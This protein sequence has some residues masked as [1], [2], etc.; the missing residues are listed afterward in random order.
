MIKIIPDKNMRLTQ[1]DID[2][3]VLIS[4]IDL[5]G[6][7]VHF[8]SPGDDHGAYVVKPENGAA[9]I[10][11]VLLTLAGTVS[12]YV[13]PPDYTVYSVT[14]PVAPREKPD[15]YVYTPSEVLRYETLEKQIGN[16]DDLKTTTKSDLVSAIN[17]AAESGGGGKVDAVT[18]NGVEQPVE[19]KT[20]KIT[21]DKTTVGLG[22]VDNTS[23][24]DKPISTAQATA[25]ADA[26]KAGT[27][28]QAAVAS[29]AEATQT[30]LNEKLNK[31]AVVNVTA[32]ATAGQAAD[33]KSV[34]DSLPT[35]RTWT[36]A[37]V[38]D[39]T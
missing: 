16:L 37:D 29:L 31:T 21:V 28:A 7:E 33:A 22:N 34:Y 17:E 26:K 13:Y 3:K 24:A 27:D 12:V 10:P 8:A 18:V 1:W 14:L 25:I 38:E 23:D 35:I 19:D 20:A 9:V 11:N 2:R 15:D 6:A 36:S 5:D 39:A 32:S 30:A 4:G